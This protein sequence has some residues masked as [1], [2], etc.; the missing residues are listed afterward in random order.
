MNFPALGTADVGGLTISATHAAGVLR[1]ASGGTT[2]RL[3]LAADGKVG[4]GTTSPVALLSNSSASD[5]NVTANGLQWV[6]ANTDNYVA[7]FKTGKYGLRILDTSG[8]GEAIVATGNIT[9]LAGFFAGVE[10][11]APAAPAANGFRLYGEDNGLGK[12]RLMVRFGTGVPQQIAIE[13]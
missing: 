3:T 9:I 10:M 8:T 1:L 12:T 6:T 5:G 7:Y 4:I 13:P 11:T 2:P